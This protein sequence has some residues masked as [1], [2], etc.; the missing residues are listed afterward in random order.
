MH[1]LKEILYMTVCL[2]FMSC[3]NNKSASQNQNLKRAGE[4]LDS[5]YANYAVEGTTL[6]RETFPFD[7]EGKATYLADQEQAQKTNPYSYLW[8]YSGGLSA[9]TVLYEGSNDPKNIEIMK[10][11]V[12]PGLEMYFDTSRSPHAYASY[13]NTAA[14]SDR[15]YDDNVWLGIDFTDLYIL[16]KEE[17]YL[18]KAKLIWQFV[19]SGKDDVLGGGIYWCEQKK[20]SKNTCS[21][22]PGCVYALK[23]FT[24]TG[25]SSY[26][27]KGLELYNWT[28]EK[29]Q[30]STDFLYY[31]N[32]KLN[33]EIEKRKYAYNSG[34]ML[35]AS[36][37]LY[38]LTNDKAYLNEA[39]Q[40]ARSSYNHFFSNYR[41][42]KEESFMMLRNEDVWFTAVM[43]RGFIELYHI[44]KNKEYVNAFQSNL[45]Y[46][47]KYMREENGLFN[48]D[49]NGQKKDDSKWLLTQFAMVEMYARIAMIK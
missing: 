44:D 42:E 29:L 32:I 3:I 28:K 16:T 24:A 4:T 20:E 19:E 47:W 10:N 38:K 11:K 9:I 26:F 15:F 46:A 41:I 40:I 6:L 18:D 7:E 25:D 27:E 14:K 36:A 35:Q 12:L 30:D 37:L 5:I 48:T 8:P 17:V 13:I 1:Y 45:N 43:F 22:A 31:D 23:L 34:Q 21:N 49:W 33:G 39:Q 2:L